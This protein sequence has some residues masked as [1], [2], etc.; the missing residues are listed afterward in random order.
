MP[1]HRTHGV[2]APTMFAVPSV[3]V[4]EHQMYLSRACDLSP[5]QLLV[6]PE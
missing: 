6:H 5:Y 2:T 1:H 4:V 3:P